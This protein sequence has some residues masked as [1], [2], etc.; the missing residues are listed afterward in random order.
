MR[1]L[2]ENL[3]LTVEFIEFNTVIRGA[4]ISLIKIIRRNDVF[5]EGDYLRGIHCMKILDH[6]GFQ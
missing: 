6:N 4:R 2:N 1:E 3:K 5:L